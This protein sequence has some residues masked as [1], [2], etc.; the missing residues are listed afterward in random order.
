MSRPYSN[1]S[2]DRARAREIHAVAVGQDHALAAVVA[3]A[4]RDDA[5][6]TVLLT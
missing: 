5:G 3:L 2:V 4:R 6:A 1:D